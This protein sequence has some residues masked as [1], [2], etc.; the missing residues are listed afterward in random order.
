MFLMF[1]RL[2]ATAKPHQEFRCPRCERWP[3]LVKI[4][5]RS[6]GSDSFFECPCGAQIWD[7]AQTRER[8]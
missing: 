3:R 5:P 8:L 4:E 1:E 6:N 7:R 2:S